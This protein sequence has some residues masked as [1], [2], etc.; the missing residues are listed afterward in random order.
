VTH[1]ALRALR[2]LLVG[3]DDDA[4]RPQ[5]HPE[6]AEAI[7]RAESFG[8]TLVGKSE[9]SATRAAEDASFEVRIAIR[10]GHRYPLRADVRGGRVNLT[11]EQGVVTAAEAY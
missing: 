9:S 7:A 3:T 8:A 6:L 2:R 5:F 4:P 1:N 11:I 10:D